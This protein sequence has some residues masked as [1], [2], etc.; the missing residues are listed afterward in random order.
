MNKKISALLFLVFISL[1]LYS[2]IF[3]A[4]NSALNYRLIGFVAFP[5]K[6]HKECQI[7]IAKG[8]HIVS[9]SFNT[10]II[11]T[12]LCR[13]D[14]TIIEVPWFGS[15]YTWRTV[16]GIGAKA[17][18]GEL[19]HFATSYSK[20]TD[21]ALLR[22]RV[23]TQAQKYKSAYSFIDGSAVLYDMKGK[24]VWH[25]P[26]RF[27]GSFGYIRDLKTTSFGTV[28]F[29]AGDKAYEVGYNGDV[30]W[31]APDDGAVSGGRREFY[32]HEFTRLSNGNY[33]I[34]GN[35]P[36]EVPTNS[37]DSS[38]KAKNMNF[39]FGTVIEYDKK[40]KV[41]WSW[42]SSKYY[43]ESDLVNYFNSSNVSGISDVHENAFYF[44]EK[45]KEIYL[46]FKG[47]SR[48]L[49]IK[50]PEGNV[51]S[52]YGE[53][54]KPGMT[55]VNGNGLF[56]GQ[57]ACKYSR[58]GCLFLFNNNGCTKK[59]LPKVKQFKEMNDANH[60]LKKVWEYQC[61]VENNMPFEFPTGGSVVELPDHS[62]FVCMGS[63]YGKVFI[64]NM[65]KKV[66]WSAI[67]EHWDPDKNKW[68]AVRGYRASMII[69][70]KALENL[71]W[72][73]KK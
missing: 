66:L 69:D 18:Y 58:V 30:L 46:S 38:G 31:E 57:H 5:A 52:T 32:H 63:E 40:G 73:V 56:C 43:R 44:D 37:T 70:D 6:E 1:N 4:E 20:N 42:K 60:T 11:K 39:L 64:V 3:P 7:Q 65:D 55:T 54:Y 45:A 9:D 25:L 41:V 2:Q 26:A 29:I 23:T 14:R 16:T 22:L 34:L 19:H 48:V 12:A 33:M 10:H 50:Y 27:D 28:T 62:L 17:N 72:A 13:S 53:I 8:N 61:S 71:V 67:P 35:E 51:L 15:N 49:K 68:E 36:Y 21:T 24:P 47:I 59:G